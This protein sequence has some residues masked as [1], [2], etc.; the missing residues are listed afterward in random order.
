[1]AV[2]FFL[3]RH[4]KYCPWDYSFACGKVELVVFLKMKIDLVHWWL[5]PL[6][7]ATWEIEA[8]ESQVLQQRKRRADGMEEGKKTLSLFLGTL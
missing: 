1:M 4:I 3:L 8:G 5:T 7:L 6:I 2:P